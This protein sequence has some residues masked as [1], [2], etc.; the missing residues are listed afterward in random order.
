MAFPKVME[1][2]CLGRLGKVVRISPTRIRENAFN[3]HLRGNSG[4]AV[5]IIKNVTSPFCSYH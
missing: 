1:N 3:Y 2:L 5:R 4:T